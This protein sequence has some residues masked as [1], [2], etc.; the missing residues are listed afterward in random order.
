MSDCIKHIRRQMVNAGCAWMLTTYFTVWQIAGMQKAS[1]T[2]F[3]LG[4]QCS[5]EWTPDISPA[6][7]SFAQV[8]PC[9]H[10]QTIVPQPGFWCIWNFTYSSTN[11]PCRRQMISISYGSPDEKIVTGVIGTRL[12]GTTLTSVT[13]IFFHLPPPTVLYPCEGYV[14]SFQHSNKDLF[15]V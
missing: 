8:S 9:G 5:T 6:S 7:G 12:I 14:T 11:H 1:G 15:Y 4:Y 10:N 13:G 2:G 3:E